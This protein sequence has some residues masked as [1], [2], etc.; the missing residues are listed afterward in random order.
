M[1]GVD[2][3][4]KAIV[5]MWE[6]RA[7][8]EGMLAASELFRNTH[9]AFAERGLPGSA[10]PIPRIPALVDRAK[11]RLARFFDKF[12]AQL[13][14]NEFV[15]GKRYTIADATTLCGIDFAKWTDVEIPRHCRNLR[16]WYDAVSARPSAKA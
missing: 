8:E 14:H 7:N 15:A 12:D 13:A 3:K 2:A 11:A 6:K 10:Q 4:D 9:P 1:M 16:R 5:E